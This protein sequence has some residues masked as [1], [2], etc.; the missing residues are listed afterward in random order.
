M[1]GRHPGHHFFLK[2]I[3]VHWTVRFVCPQHVLSPNVRWPLCWLTNRKGYGTNSP[4]G[5]ELTHST[6]LLLTSCPTRQCG[7]TASWQSLWSTWRHCLA[8]SSS[9]LRRSPTSPRCWPTS[10]AWPSGRS[11]PTLCYSSFQ[12]S[13][14]PHLFCY[15]PNWSISPKVLSC[16]LFS[17][18]CAGS[19]LWSQIRQLCGEGHRDIW[20]LLHPVLCGETPENGSKGWSRGQ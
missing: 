3:F 20:G 12:R 19:G 4:A 15:L 9:P 8:S 5:A 17:W 11:S 7:A 2:I 18:S 10:L 6:Y 1:A 16:K 13:V 14:L